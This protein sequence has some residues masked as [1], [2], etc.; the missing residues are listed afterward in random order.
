MEH[1]SIT[2]PDAPH[3]FFDRKATEF[4][5]ASEDAWR[6]MLDFIGAAPVSQARLFNTHPSGA[7]HAEERIEA[8]M[9]PGGIDGCGNAQNCVQVCPKE[10]PLTTSLGDMM[11]ATAKEALVSLFRK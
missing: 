11:R 3:S 10:I 6:Q 9:E 8:L 2:Y 4:A 5:N 7:M 1:R